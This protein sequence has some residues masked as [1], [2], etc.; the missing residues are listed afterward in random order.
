MKFELFKTNN[1]FL[2]FILALIINNMNSQ[3]E[4]ECSSNSISYSIVANVSKY[5]EKQKDIEDR[6]IYKEP[7]IDQLKSKKVGAMKE[8]EFDNSKFDN[9]K[10]YDSLDDLIKDLQSRQ[11]DAIILNEGYSN[12]TQYLTDDLSMIQKP[13]EVL[14]HAF[15][16]Q[17]ENTTISDAFNDY[18]TKG[19]SN[20]NAGSKESFIK[21]WKSI[22]Y[23]TSNIEDLKKSLTGENGSINALFKL[24]NEPY[25][26][27]EENGDIT[28]ME[29]EVLY[30][31]AKEKGYSVNLKEANTYEEL[32][33]GL[34]NKSADVIG[35]LLPIRDAYK[36]DITY[37]Q[38]Y[39]YSSNHIVVRYENLNDSLTWYEPYESTDELDGENL[40]VLKGSTLVELTS[41]NFPESN[42]IEKEDS[43]DLFEGLLMDEFEGFLM[44]KPTAAFFK[45]RFPERITYFDENFYDNDYGFAFQNNA[46]GDKYKTDFNDYLKSIDVSQ[47]KELYD[48]WNALDTSGLTIDKNL[49][50]SDVLINAA[51]LPDIKPLCFQES[52]EMKGLEIELLY[53]FAKEKH[54]NIK[55]TQISQVEERITYIE[56]GNADITG[57]YFTITDE[58]KKKSI[59]F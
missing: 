53:K 47:R 32:I 24:N 5:L 7:V 28:G 18:L 15:G 22:N 43:I 27:K 57:G 26:Y 3:L 17:K 54:Y 50:E 58:R 44:D 49:N 51:F 45:S 14:P 59:F 21:K 25:A 56:D 33:E 37:S 16:F 55:L 13:V 39:F 52:G 9:I 11:L 4:P 40:G 41:E 31:I 1:L 34:K 36:N 20:S 23:K 30:Y 19:P 29:L 48:K 2:I 38:E 12:K 42:V 6:E 35:G 46:N 8:F 10:E